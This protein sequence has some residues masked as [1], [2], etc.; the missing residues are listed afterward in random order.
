MKRLVLGVA[1]AAALI[2]TAVPALAVDVYV[3]PGGIGVNAEIG[4]EAAVLHGWLRF[5]VGKG[6]SDSARVA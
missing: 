3:G 5:L 6:D 4:C 1:A 2:V